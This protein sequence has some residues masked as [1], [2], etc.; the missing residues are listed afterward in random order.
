MNSNLLSVLDSVEEF[1]PTL[2]KVNGNVMYI[3]RIVG[4]FG[5]TSFK[6]LYELSDLEELSADLLHWF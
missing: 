3:F 5:Q 6:F 4:K 2:Q 1:L